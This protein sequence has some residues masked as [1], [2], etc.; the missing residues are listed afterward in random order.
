MT[1]YDNAKKYFRVPTVI[2]LAKQT[3]NAFA[4]YLDDVSNPSM[5]WDD[6]SENKRKA[7]CATIHDVLQN[8]DLTEADIYG[9][10]MFHQIS[11]SN[12]EAADAEL[13]HYDQLPTCLRYRYILIKLMVTAYLEKGIPEQVVPGAQLI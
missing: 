8:T 7:L 13:H 10:H 3:Y 11:T 6:L 2:M 4:T 12:D 5:V 1:Q 9:R